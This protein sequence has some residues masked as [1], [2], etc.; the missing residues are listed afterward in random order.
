MGLEMLSIALGLSS[1]SRLLVGRKVIVW[2]D[3]T[4]AESAAKT[5]SAKQFDHACLA[6]CLWLRAA[7]LGIEMVVKRVPTKD[8][9]ADLPSRGE[10][11]LLEWMGAERQEAKLDDMF[12]DV[13]SWKSLSLRINLPRQGSL[14][15]Y[16]WIIPNYF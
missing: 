15:G 5:G 4:G 2:S 1:F 9:I 8:N 12:L 16:F 10:F 7:Q 6:H 3:N 13:A 14:F 11:A